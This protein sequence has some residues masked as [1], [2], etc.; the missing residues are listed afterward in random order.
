ML[1]YG[2]LQVNTLLTLSDGKSDATV[3]NDTWRNY[4]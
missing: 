4:D 2:F 1:T 3:F